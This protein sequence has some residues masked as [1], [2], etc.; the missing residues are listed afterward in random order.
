MIGCVFVQR[1]GV[2]ML[3]I[4]AFA[5]PDLPRVF[6]NL[7]G[8]RVRPHA[9]GLKPFLKLGAGYAFDLAGGVDQAAKGL[10]M[11]HPADQ[12]DHD[13]RQHQ[14][15]HQKQHE[16]AFVDIDPQFAHDDCHQRIDIG[17][18][19]DRHRVL[20]GPVLN[21]QPMRPRGELRRR[22]AVDGNHDCDGKDR[23]RQHRV[24]ND[25]QKPVCGFPG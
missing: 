25:L 21:D 6:R 12:V 13:D 3:N 23:H 1:L 18:D 11:Q 19:K 4:A 5:R 20:G 9:G 10:Q 7:C 16:G 14:H 15:R 17:A 2:D 8:Q 24:R 22:R